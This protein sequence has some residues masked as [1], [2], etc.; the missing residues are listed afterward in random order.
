MSAY[1]IRIP[2]FSDEKNK[3]LV[4]LV[5]HDDKT[6]IVFAQHPLNK[7]GPSVVNSVEEIAKTAF[8]TVPQLRDMSDKNLSYY[9]TFR[10][11]AE[12]SRFSSERK[13]R[14]SKVEF[15]RGGKL[16]TGGL[17]SNKEWTFEGANWVS[18]ERDSDFVKR[19][20]LEAWKAGYAVPSGLAPA[21][22][23]TGN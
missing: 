1:V 9:T 18:D 12:N 7:N 2:S 4:F 8:D 22:R 3:F 11:A 10:Y 16:R 13:G 23:R 15:K 6:A 20:D 14:V 21:C 17:L 19:I 5:P